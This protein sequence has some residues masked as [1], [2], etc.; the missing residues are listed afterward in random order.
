M[1]DD[2]YSIFSTVLGI[3][4]TH[5]CHHL[6]LCTLGLWRL[7][8]CSYSD[9]VEEKCFIFSPAVSVLPACLS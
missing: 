9:R 2:L 3:K 1:K 4:A 5:L 7:D 8:Y 6:A